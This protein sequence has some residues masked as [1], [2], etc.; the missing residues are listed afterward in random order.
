MNWIKSNPFVSALAGIT[1]VICAVLIFLGTRGGA[2]YG[3]AKTGFEDAYQGVSTSEGI[4]LYPTAE[5][6]DGKRKALN[7][8]RESIT[9]LRAL[10]DKYRPAN[11]DNLT[12]QEFTG[13]LKSSTT[14]VT[15]ALKEAG[16]EVPEGFFM[17]FEGYRDQLAQSEATGVLHFEVEGIKN[18]LLNLAEA[19]PGTLISLYREPIPEETGG[20]YTPP[21][22]AV[23]RTFGFELVFKGSEAS[24]RE[25]LSSLGDID[26]YYYVI[27][28]LK[29]QNED[30]APPRVADAEFETA[31]T[32]AAPV[33]ASPFGV[34][35]EIPEQEVAEEGEE[36]GTAE[37]AGTGE[38]A[39]APAV[40]ETAPA[41]TSRI[42]AQVLG[43]EELIV[44]IR[45]DL[46]MFL[47]A[48][49]LPQP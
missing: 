29:I 38:E 19:R 20:T 49:E 36:S 27:R 26:P 43:D 24:V 15:D 3:E 44:F 9:A 23:A 28:T 33:E 13:R 21:E 42:L 17:G 45:F 40:A 22:N 6:R 25:F 11:L 37:E 8:Y 35:F 16:V 7:E 14:E 34:A 5:N 32:E 30:S 48:K 18:A 4:P 2:R 47:P 41:D 46:V 31:V 1:L 10:F 39:E 12:T